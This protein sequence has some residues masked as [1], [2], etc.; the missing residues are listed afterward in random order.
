MKKIIY[1]IAAALLIPILVIILYGEY[2]LYKMDQEEITFQT[3]QIKEY[4]TKF[5]N[6]PNPGAA[7]VL[8]G[9]YY[10][11]IKAVNDNDKALY[12]AKECI[13]LGGE[14]NKYA[15]VEV[16]FVIACIYNEKK[17]KNLAR[18]YL[19][20]AVDLDKDDLIGKDN[21]IDKYGLQDIWDKG[22]EKKKK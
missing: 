12:Y 4:E 6:N 10:H 1:A 5:K 7:Y 3:S 21:A 16:N 14:K 17:E 11:N 13:K 22:W 9:L 15:R 19:K 18:Y 8:V 20:R 2:I